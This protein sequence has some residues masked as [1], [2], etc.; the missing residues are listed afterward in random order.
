MTDTE[1]L[2]E[3]LGMLKSNIHTCWESTNPNVEFENLVGYIEF[4]R[5]ENREEN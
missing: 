5:E 4:Y 1:I 2:N 3:L